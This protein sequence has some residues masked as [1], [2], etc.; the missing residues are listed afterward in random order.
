VKIRGLP[1]LSFKQVKGAY[2]PVL[3]CE[4]EVFSKRE[5]PE[6]KRPISYRKKMTFAM[7]FEGIA[8]RFCDQI[9]GVLLENLSR[10]SRKLSKEIELAVTG[11]PPD[12]SSP[13]V[14]SLILTEASKRGTGKILYSEIV[15]DWTQ[16]DF[17]LFT[18]KVLSRI[19]ESEES[20]LN[21]RKD[22]DENRLLDL[23]QRIVETEADLKAYTGEFD[24]T[25]GLPETPKQRRHRAS[26]G[27][28]ASAAEHRLSGYRLQRSKITEKLSHDLDSIRNKY[29]KMRANAIK[30]LTL[31]PEPS[32]ISLDTYIV[33]LPRFQGDLEVSPSRSFPIIW[34]G[35]SGLANIGLCKVCG[36]SLTNSNASICS[37]CTELICE[38]DTVT[39]DQ[40]AKVL[41]KFDS[42]T[43]PSCASLL[44]KD[45][46]T[47]AC[48]TCGTR[49]CFKCRNF[50][51]ECGRTLCTTH[52]SKCSRC[53]T[54]LCNLHAL[55][56]PICSNTVC[57][58]E[59]QVCLGCR[60]SV[61]SVHINPC[62]KCGNRICTTCVQEKRS[63][64]ALV[65][66]RLHEVRCVF[67]IEQK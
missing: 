48:A 52:T 21:E 34:N 18:E 40:C 45:E 63:V 47:F 3:H 46:A 57:N 12:V 23:E 42:W 25:S 6:L 28:K 4:A 38:Q 56:C 11:S 15:E 65:R 16:D 13:L 27:A 2:F 22:R 37:A 31:R 26:L 36:I 24:E 29:E 17:E 8:P 50:C 64:R 14:R 19:E 39:C 44:C 59:V 10:D 55:S 60:R 9:E 30:E 20:E 53:K 43:C 33:W 5:I 35:M 1:N 49:A 66:G 51:T 67:C 54:P 62:P 41:C 61:C 7:V 32:E 58:A